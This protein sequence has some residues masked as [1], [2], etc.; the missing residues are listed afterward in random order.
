MKREARNKAHAP[1][2]HT[3]VKGGGSITPSGHQVP[4]EHGPR[5]SNNSPAGAGRNA[6]LSDFSREQMRGKG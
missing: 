4:V 1:K 6:D 2:L 5:G 3:E